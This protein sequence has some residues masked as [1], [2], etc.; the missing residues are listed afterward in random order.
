MC[1]WLWGIFLLNTPSQ[2]SSELPK[3]HQV[4]CLSLPTKPA[5]V[6]LPKHPQHTSH[7]VGGQGKSLPQY[8][9]TL[10]PQITKLVYI[11]IF[12]WRC[13]KHQSSK[14]G[15]KNPKLVQEVWSKQALKRYWGKGNFRIVPREN[16]NVNYTKLI[17]AI[18]QNF[19]SVP[20]HMQ[21]TNHQV[22]KQQVSIAFS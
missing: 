8:Q 20:E 14:Y 21:S 11:F 7:L 1:W 3:I 5:K 17:L 16:K 19:S 12:I 13:C 2:Y 15:F 18:K 4:K 6:R 10:F 22:T 9:L